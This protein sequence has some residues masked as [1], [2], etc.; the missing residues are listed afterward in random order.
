MET[1]KMEKAAEVKNIKE[2]FEEEE[3]NKARIEEKNM[4]GSQERRK[5]RTRV[6]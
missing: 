5:I 6:V 1:T 2:Q 4:N 3:E